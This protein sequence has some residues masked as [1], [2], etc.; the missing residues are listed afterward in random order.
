[1]ITIKKALLG[2]SIA[3]STLASSIAHTTPVDGDDWL[4]TQGNQIVDKGGN[5]VW[6]TG[7]NWFGFNATER[8]FH[9]LWSVNLESTLQTLAD[10]GINILRVPIS[11]EL[12]WEWRNGVFSVPGINGS[13]NADLIGQTNLQVFDRF[14]DV[15]R[16]IGMKVMIDV[17]SAEADNSGHFARLWYKDAITPEIFY[18]SWEWI[19]ERY[20]NN[21][22]IIAMDIENEPHGKPWADPDYAKWDSTTDVNNFKHACETASNRILA[23]NPEMLVLCE[24][25]ESY[26]RDGISW[27]DASA[28][29]EFFNTWWGG[30]LRGVREHP[31]DLGANQDQ[32][33]Y[34]PHDYG[35]LVFR[36]QWFFDGFTRETLQRDAWNDNWLFIHDENIAP[37]L[38]GEWGGFID[39]SDNQKWMEALRDQIIEDRLHH[40]FWAVNPNSGDTGGLLLNDWVSIDEEKYAILKP[41]LWQDENG[42]F[43]SLDHEVPLG[44]SA[45]SVTLSEFYGNQQPSIGITSPN[46]GTNFTVDTSFN[47]NIDLSQIT[48]VNVYV[49]DVL[50]ASNQSGGLLAIN[51]PTTVGT[52]NVRIEAVDANGTELGL[53]AVRSYDAVAEVVLLPAISIASPANNVNVDTN[54]Q[55]TLNVDYEN[56]DGFN[57]T[58]AGQTQTILNN[59]LIALTAPSTAGNYPLTVTAIDS[60]QQTLDATTSINVTV[61]NVVVPPQ[62]DVTCS[63]GSANVWSGGFTIGE[64]TVTNSGNTALSDWSV[65][66]NLPANSSLSNGWNA[67]YTG[68]T[69]DVTATNMV[70][71]GNLAPNQSVSFGFQGTYTGNY[72]APSCTAN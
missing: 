70:Y 44:S 56:A 5:A 52:F 59:T 33:V 12:L 71:N 55:F 36:Q 45:T 10:R 62:G 35:P 42:K 40:T 29:T 39:A 7:A 48:A 8:T 22:T 2:A 66:I 30:N 38:I 24:G 1:M 41:A 20:K 53:Q 46:A 21:D 51:V 64:I 18:E 67:N 17:H 14:L 43:V 6:L 32:L 34:S 19:T 28:G 9:G 65:T 11:T 54:E 4:H 72:V 25:I 60:T 63:V 57:V 58:F 47:I 23:I 68:T 15:A 61:N 26:P 16:N 49:N 69:G 27:D 3:L 37:L 31:I 13:T 50:S